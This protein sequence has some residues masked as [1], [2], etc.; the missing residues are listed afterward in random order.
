MRR[1]R[2]EWLYR[3]AQERGACARRY[4]IGMAQFLTLVLRQARGARMH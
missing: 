4:T 3:W 2:L 1:L